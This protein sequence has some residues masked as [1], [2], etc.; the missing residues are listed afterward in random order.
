MCV[1]VCVRVLGYLCS[2]QLA[3]GGVA[4]GVANCKK[5]HNFQMDSHTCTRFNG[6]VGHELSICWGQLSKR[7]RGSGSGL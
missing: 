2:Y 3:K 4:F 1:C 6:K 7:G 5:A